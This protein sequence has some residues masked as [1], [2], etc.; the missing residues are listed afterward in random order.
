MPWRGRWG[1]L[2]EE[3]CKEMYGVFCVHFGYR[4]SVVDRVAVAYFYVFT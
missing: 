4:G 2:F 3:E 1:G